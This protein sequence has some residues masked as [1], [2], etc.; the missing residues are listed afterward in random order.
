MPLPTVHLWVRTGAHEVP[1]RLIKEIATTAEART[2]QRLPD[3]SGAPD[4]DTR[5]FTRLNLQTLSGEWFVPTLVNEIVI[6][7]IDGDP[8]FHIIYEKDREKIPQSADD[9][10]S[11][12]TKRKF[13]MR[14]Q[15]M[16]DLERE[17]DQTH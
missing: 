3:L 9:V 10:P 5:A 7:P 14:E 2:S 13:Q 15:F 11:E 12:E 8:R 6:R 16:R 17:N 1:L 4:D